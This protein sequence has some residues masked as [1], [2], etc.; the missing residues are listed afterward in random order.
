MELEVGPAAGREGEAQDI[1]AGCCRGTGLL[2]AASG[3]GP[4]PGQPR[5]P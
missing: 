1:R 3:A 4:S 5:H 2:H